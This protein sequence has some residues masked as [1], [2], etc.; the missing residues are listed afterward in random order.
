M[1]THKL[2]VPVLVLTL[3]RKRLFLLWALEGFKSGK[4]ARKRTQN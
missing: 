2:Q 4:I 3:A 1:T